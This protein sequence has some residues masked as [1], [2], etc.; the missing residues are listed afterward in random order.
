MK[1]FSCVIEIRSPSST[2]QRLAGFGWVYEYI[3]MQPFGD[4]CLEVYFADEFSPFDFI[5]VNAGLHSL[6]WDYAQ[7]PDILESEKEQCMAYSRLCR[8]NLEIE[9]AI[10]P[11]HL[12]PSPKV[13]AALL[14]AV[15]AG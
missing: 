11:L 6:F 5:S 14:F 3:T 2:A 15:S 12:P 10:L 4:L 1:E 7:G 8:D 9:L 13:I